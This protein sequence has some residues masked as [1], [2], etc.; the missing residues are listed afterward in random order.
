MMER[1]AKLTVDPRAEAR[2]LMEDALIDAELQ[3]NFGDMMR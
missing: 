2:A 1:Y 3:Q